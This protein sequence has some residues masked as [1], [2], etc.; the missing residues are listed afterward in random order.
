MFDTKQ[1]TGSRP[2][3]AITSGQYVGKLIRLEPFEQTYD[4]QTKTRIRWIWHVAPIATPRQPVRN[5]DGEPWEFFSYSGTAT[6]QKSTA[7]PW[8]QTLLGRPIQPGE[9][10]DALSQQLIGKVGELWIKVETVPGEHGQEPQTKTSLL[11]VDPFK[12]GGAVKPEPVAAAAPMKAKAAAVAVAE[13][14]DDGLP[15]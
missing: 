15:F 8:I 12:P 5:T 2:V 14:D 6:G 13:P 10:G 9:D 11:S 4:G 1:S 3:E 7:G